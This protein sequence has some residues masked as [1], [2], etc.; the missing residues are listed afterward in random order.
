LEALHSAYRNLFDKV[1]G[2]RADIVL[3]TIISHYKH[4]WMVHKLRPQILRTEREES[5]KRMEKQYI[6][7]ADKYLQRSTDTARMFEISKETEKFNNLEELVFENTNDSSTNAEKTGSNLSTT[8]TQTGN[9]S[10]TK[11]KSASSKCSYGCKQPG[12][13]KCINVGQKKKDRDNIQEK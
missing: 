12:N 5:E 8:K 11:P 6:V 13:A 2:K 1:I 3:T 4:L 7:G 10:A 9:D